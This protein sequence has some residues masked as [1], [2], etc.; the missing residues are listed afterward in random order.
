MVFLFFRNLYFVRIWML[1]HI[2]WFECRGCILIR[3]QLCYWQI[4]LL[5][6]GF[7]QVFSLE[8]FWFLRQIY[9]ILSVDWNSIWTHWGIQYIIYL[10]ISAFNGHGFLDKTLRLLR[11]RIRF[12]LLGEIRF[13]GCIIWVRVDWFFGFNTRY[14]YWRE[15]VL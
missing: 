6:L 3:H 12:T 11:Y 8:I 10:I 1:F 4:L 2:S 13:V 14:I 15:Y 9:V 5:V 7:T